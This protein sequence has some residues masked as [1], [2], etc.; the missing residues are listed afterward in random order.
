MRVYSKIT[1]EERLWK[2]FSGCRSFNMAKLGLNTQDLSKILLFFV[3]QNW[4]GLKS[5]IFE[6]FWS[7]ISLGYLW[8][9]ATTPLPL[10]RKVR[11]VE[12]GG[13]GE[14]YK[15]TRK[16]W[17]LAGK[18]RQNVEFQNI[19]LF[20]LNADNTFKL[21]EIY[22][23]LITLRMT[24]MKSLFFVSR[25]TSRKKS[26]LI[27]TDWTKNNMFCSYLDDWLNLRNSW[28]KSR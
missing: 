16:G 6:S 2:Y 19:Y 25:L 12:G 23:G 9:D 15:V 10:W 18:A 26:Q 22:S 27:T 28:W 4:F 3:Q 8:G 20:H 21:Y 11:G 17:F 7:K 1:F 13:V 14:I 5:Y 24:C